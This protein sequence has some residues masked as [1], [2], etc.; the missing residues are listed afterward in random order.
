MFSEYEKP[1]Y[2]EP[3]KQDY[4]SNI[5]SKSIPFNFMTYVSLKL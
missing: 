1:S 4:V 5:V 3:K 2:P